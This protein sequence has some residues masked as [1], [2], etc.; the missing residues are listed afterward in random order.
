M[1]LRFD[2]L[3]KSRD[4]RLLFIGQTVSFLGS[5]VT[6]TVIPYQVFELTKS[7]LQV[8]VISI[9]QLIATLV[10]GI[11]GGSLA[12][13][14]DRRR[15]LI[16]AE[17]IMAAAMIA[18]AWNA[19]LPEPSLRL[20]F[21]LTFLLQA[22]NA[23]HRPAAEAMTQLMVSREDFASVAALGSLR[24]SVGAI[25]GPAFGGLI[26]AAGG[27]RAAYIFD[28]ATFVF[29]LVTVLLISPSFAV[30]RESRTSFLHDMRVG[31]RFALGHQVVL[32]SYLIDI[33]AMAFA[34]P[35]ALFPEMAQSWG[36]AV[37]LGWLY[38]AMAIGSLGVSLFAGLATR[39]RHAGRTLVIAAGL[40]TLFIFALGFAPSLPWAVACL[41]LAG[42]AD[43]FSGLAR[44]VIWNDAIPNEFRGR[45]AGLEMISYMAGPLVGNFR[46]GAMAKSMGIAA[47]ISSGAAVGLGLIG[48][49]TLF[50]FPNLWRYRSPDGNT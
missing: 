5:M 10:F 14:M 12:D 42:V 13:R 8:G 3:L 27:T 31:M 32:G 11:L 40:W 44:R 30:K 39:G 25:V 9:V 6:Y 15:L 38:A 48:A 43:T 50:V 22:A 41:A 23:Y 7:S 49:G 26:L 2:P 1:L 35:V 4:F 45:M 46:V 28:A 24:Y 21:A 33:V 18:L 16:G 19:H 47:S 37:A 17:L 29:A 20:L 34:F 36:G